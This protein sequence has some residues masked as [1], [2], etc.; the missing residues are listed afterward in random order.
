MPLIKGETKVA[1]RQRLFEA[2]RRGAVPALMH[3]SGWPQP[4]VVMRR[5][6]CLCPAG[7]V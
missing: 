6:Q 3:F 1:E 2:F 7:T 4:G 5:P